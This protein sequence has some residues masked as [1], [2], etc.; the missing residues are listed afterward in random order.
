MPLIET[1][2]RPMRRLRPALAGLGLVA[3][4]IVGALA[5]F[6]RM[7][8]TIAT[9]AD[10]IG[11]PVRASTADG[12]RIFLL[13]SQWKTFRP[14]TSLRSASTSPTYT[15]LLIDLWAFDAATGEKLW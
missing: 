8:Q 2:G 15:D 7:S 10:V 1:P 12:D 4:L 5:L 3:L 9:P 14:F 13:T 11:A 6:G